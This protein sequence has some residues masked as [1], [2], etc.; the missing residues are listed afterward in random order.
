M[1]TGACPS[2]LKLNMGFNGEDGQTLGVVD[3]DGISGTSCNGSVPPTAVF[4]LNKQ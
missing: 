2:T 4:D 1:F 3:L